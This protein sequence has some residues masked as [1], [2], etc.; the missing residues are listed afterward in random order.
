MSIEGIRVIY[1]DILTLLSIFNGTV[2]M[3]EN[4]S[5]K[6]EMRVMLLDF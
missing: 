1:A 4:S 3:N 6:C 2:N 5:G